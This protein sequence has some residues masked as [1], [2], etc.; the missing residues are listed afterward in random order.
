M[1]IHI[2]GTTP[3]DPADRTE[4]VPAPTKIVPAQP[5]ERDTPDHLTN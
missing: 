2:H 4:V 3:N 5:M 1:G